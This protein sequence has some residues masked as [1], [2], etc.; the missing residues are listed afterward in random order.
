[1]GRPELDDVSSSRLKMRP[2]IEKE[3][4]NA[5]VGCGFRRVALDELEGEKDESVEGETQRDVTKWNRT[6][7]LYE[8][9]SERTVAG[10]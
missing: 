10:C 2:D 8:R 9:I 6:V 4:E 1:M 3:I 5:V 7:H